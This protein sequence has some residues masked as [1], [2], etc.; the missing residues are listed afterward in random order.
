MPIG[1]EIEHAVMIDVGVGL[2]RAPGPACRISVESSMHILMHQF[3]QIETKGIAGRS[4]DHIGSDTSR[5]RHIAAGVAD[6]SVAR[7]VTESDP[8]LGARCL[9]QTPP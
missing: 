9:R 8:D 2:A 4:N 1:F 3:L 5:A 6:G 7:V